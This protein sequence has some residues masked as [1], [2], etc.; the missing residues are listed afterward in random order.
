MVEHIHSAGLPP[1]LLRM[2]DNENPLG[3]SPKAL[4][5]IQTHMQSLNR[6]EWFDSD[7]DGNLTHLQPA[8]MLIRALADENGISLPE[9][10]DLEK[11]HPIFLA[12]GVDQILKLLAVAYLS[13]G[14]GEL[15][16]AEVTYGEISE[17][18]R[19]I[20]SA[21]IDT[22]VVQVPMTA[23]HKHDLD[24]ML[25]AITPRTRLMVVTNP[26]N[27]TG[28]L[29][30]YEAISAFVN[31]VPGEI[32][33][34]IDE[35]Y[36]HFV[37]QPNYQ[38]AMSLALSRDN[39][40]VVRTF[41]KV[42]GIRGVMVGYAVSSQAIKEKLMLYNSG[43]T[44]PLS[45]MAALAALGDHDHVQ[46]SRDTVISSRERLFHEFEAMNLEYIPSETNF[47]QVN[48]ERDTEEVRLALWDKRIAVSPRGSQVMKG[49]IR[50]SV[51]TM[52]EIETFLSAF[53]EVLPTISRLGE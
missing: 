43:R 51:G 5:A 19:E 3:P 45:L 38:S 14:H 29:L 12:P 30:T 21:G 10:F 32:V 18:A 39:V 46:R 17:K 28:S 9:P 53:K 13:P 23:D 1:G 40:V 31:S 4:D 15:I 6:Y 37:K 42:Y 52:N 22:N 49:W 2:M 48:V 41:A 25:E 20:N 24:A 34:V 16:E 8:E 35:A 36:F 27:P 26:N 11:P 44:S 7:S 33:V 50:I 47:V